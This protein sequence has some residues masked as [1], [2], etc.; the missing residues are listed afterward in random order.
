M[1]THMPII[2]N[3]RALLPPFVILSSLR[4]SVGSSK[5]INP[6]QKFPDLLGACMT[7]YKRFRW[8]QCI[9]S[10]TKSPASIGTQGDL[11]GAESVYCVGPPSRA[12]Y[13]YV[14]RSHPF[15]RSCQHCLLLRVD[16][17]FVYFI[18]VMRLSAPLYTYFRY[19]VACHS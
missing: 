13:W 15:P 18:F 9:T 12:T 5:F 11:N 7:R 2:S 14:C 17:N 3:C 10:V 16:S 8:L 1:R 19:H 6:F 4:R